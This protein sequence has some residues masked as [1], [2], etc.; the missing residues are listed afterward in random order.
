MWTDGGKAVETAALREMNESIQIPPVASRGWRWSVHICVIGRADGA[1]HTHQFLPRRMFVAS[2][3]AWQ[4]VFVARLICR[5]RVTR[6]GLSGCSR[7]L[8]PILCRTFR[9]S[10]EAIIWPIHSVMSLAAQPCTVIQGQQ[11]GVAVCVLIVL[12][13][14]Y[15]PIL[16]SGVHPTKSAS[17]AVTLTELP[18]DRF[19]SHAVLK[20]SSNSTF[21]FCD[22]W[23]LFGNS[24]LASGLDLVFHECLIF[25][26]QPILVWTKSQG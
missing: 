5:F 14:M 24:K 25:Q 13:I 26:L 8:Y 4:R 18:H 10:Q 7:A 1:S 17:P 15:R 12:L 22:T 16:V 20:L 19:A 23:S 3:Q 11:H 6:M 9:H 2:G 21:Q